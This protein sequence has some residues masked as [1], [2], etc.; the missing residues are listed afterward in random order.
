RTILQDVVRSGK[1]GARAFQAWR[2]KNTDLADRTR[3]SVDEILDSGDPS[4]S[5]LMVAVGHLRDLSPS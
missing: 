4:L 2:E 5:R 1:G 3:K